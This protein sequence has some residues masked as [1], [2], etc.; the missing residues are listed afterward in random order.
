MEDTMSEIWTAKEKSDGLIVFEVKNEQTGQVHQEKR[1]EDALPL[2]FG[3]GGYPPMMGFFM[4]G[5]E[6]PW[7]FRKSGDNIYI[8]GPS[9]GVDGYHPIG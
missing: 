9:I 2:M 3:L 4:A 6:L 7:R 8:D 5:Q 1:R